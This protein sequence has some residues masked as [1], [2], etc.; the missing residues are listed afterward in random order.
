MPCPVNA[1]TYVNEE[2]R[3]AYVLLLRNE[4]NPLIK[5]LE[6]NINEFRNEIKTEFDELYGEFEYRFLFFDK[7]VGLITEFFRLVNDLQPDFMLA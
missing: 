3:T 2:N 4:A 5:E 7:E 6:E 1:L